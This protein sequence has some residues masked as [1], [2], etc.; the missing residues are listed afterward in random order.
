MGAKVSGLTDLSADL[1]NAVEDAIPAAKKIA[2]KGA[3]EVKKEAQRIIRA[4]SKR[5]YLPHYPR[6]ITY[7]VSAG[8]GVVEAEIGPLSGR[9]QGGLGRLL[10]YGSA[11]NAPIPHLDPALS[12]E[13]STFYRYME[14]LGEALLEGR[15]VDGPE[16]DPG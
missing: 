15:R 13:E 1:R 4:R 2:G 14:D 5:G 12:R 3:L 6:A 16:V 7:D 10:E 9:L 11:N 8:G